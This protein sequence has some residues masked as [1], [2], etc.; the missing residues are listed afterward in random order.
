MNSAITKACANLTAEQL[1]TVRDFLSA[2]SDA[3]AA[4]VDDLRGDDD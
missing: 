3:A 4:A 1:V 2:I